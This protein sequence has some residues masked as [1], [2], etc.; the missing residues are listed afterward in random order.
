MDTITNRH[1]EKLNGG[2][3]SQK[4]NTKAK[5]LKQH[6]HPEIKEDFRTHQL[7]VDDKTAKGKKW[8]NIHEL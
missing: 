3:T 6:N 5:L 2:P 7:Q 8:E 4:G 1:N